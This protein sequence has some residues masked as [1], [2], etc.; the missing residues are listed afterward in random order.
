MKTFGPHL[1]ALEFSFQFID[2][3][4]L[5]NHADNIACSNI[6]SNT[7]TH[8]HTHAYTHTHAHT[9]AHTK[10]LVRC[11]DKREGG[12]RTQTAHGTD[13]STPVGS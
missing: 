12:R 4:L 5:V 1:L 13:I 11:G 3:S 6:K 9:H 8:T 2:K 10:L 7:R